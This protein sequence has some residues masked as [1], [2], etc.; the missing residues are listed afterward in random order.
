LKGHH[1]THTNNNGRSLERT[2]Y[3]NN[4]KNEIGQEA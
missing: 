4:S 2:Q 3:K 1:I